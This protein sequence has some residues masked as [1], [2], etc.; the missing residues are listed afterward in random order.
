MKGLFIILL[1]LSATAF[2]NPILI[3]DWEGFVVQNY[4][5][6]SPIYLPCTINISSLASSNQ[7]SGTI[8]ISI[9]HSNGKTYKSKAKITG[10]F[11]SKTYQV[12]IVAEQVVYQDILPEK[13][14]WC[15]GILKGGFYRSKTYKQYL[16]K[17]MYSTKCSNQTSLLVVYKK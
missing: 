7:F 9:H 11:D 10:F 12:S 3:G 6:E 8:E 14:K 13:A 16:I 4:E 1:L 17:G 5:S 15:L 2:S